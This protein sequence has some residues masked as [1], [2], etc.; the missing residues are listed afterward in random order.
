M[1]AAA[2]EAKPETLVIADPVPGTYTVVVEN[3]D[4][5]SAEDDWS[6]GVTFESP[7]PTIETGVKEAWILT[8]RTHKGRLLTQQ[9]VIVARG[10]QFKAGRA[11]DP[12]FVKRAA[13]R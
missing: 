10:K 5:G 11:C 13:S 1:G 7:K 6:G 3:Y 12:K 9:E 4:G 2:S 8:C